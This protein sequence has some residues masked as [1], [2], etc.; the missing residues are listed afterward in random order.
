MSA[1]QERALRVGM[2]RTRRER[3][4]GQDDALTRIEVER[5]LELW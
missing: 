1:D 3:L 4:A 2:D 5:R